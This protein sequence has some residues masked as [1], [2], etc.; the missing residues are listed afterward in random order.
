[1]VFRVILPPPRKRF[2]LMESKK[3]RPNERRSQIGERKNVR[4]RVGGKGKKE[5]TDKL[6]E[7]VARLNTLLN[8]R[9]AKDVCGAPG[10]TDKQTINCVWGENKYL[11]SELFNRTN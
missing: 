3:T 4:S 9:P 6:M 5:V 11:L 8:S 2:S 10:Q 7:E 1:M